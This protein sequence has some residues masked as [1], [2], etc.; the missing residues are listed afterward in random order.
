MRKI[1]W[2]VLCFALTLG[3][4]WV[5]AVGAQQP[6][7]K[8]PASRLMDPEFWRRQALRDLIPYWAEHAPD[9]ENGGFFMNLSRDWK[10]LP[11]WDKVPALI[12][13]H[14]FGFSAAYLLSG[15]PKY[16]DIARRGAEYLIGHAWDPEYGGWFDKLTPDGKPFVETKSIPLELYTNVGLTLYYIASGEEM[17]LELVQ[18]SVDIQRTH[19]LDTKT[20][21]YVQ[22]LNR[23]LSVADYGKNKH[24]HYG[25]IG[26]LLLNLY[27]GTRDSHVLA[28]EKELAD[29][30]LAKMVDRYSWIHGFRSRFDRDWERTPALVDGREFVSVGAELTAALAFL[31]LYH[32][33][34]DPKYLAAGRRL[35]DQVTRF[36]FDRERGCWYD[37]IETVPPHRPVARPVVW[38]WVQIYGAFLQ[39]QLYRVTGDP[40]YLETFRESEEF[41]IKYMR[42]REQGGVFGSV[43][44]EGSLIGEGHKASDSEWHTSYHEM[45]HA[46]LNCLYLNLYVNRT[47]AV[48][49]YRLDGSK[50]GPRTHFVSLVDD[51]GVRIKAVTMDGQPWT[52]FDAV[53]RSVNVPAGAGHAVRVTF[54]AN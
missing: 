51:P 19:G 53:M 35:G 49:H 24:A 16:L 29:I 50:D 2:P 52:E 30:S 39:L 22:A 34:G 1:R 38:W 37:L 33:S 45:E 36:G 7:E 12:S 25:Y 18:R 15:D 8:Q 44:P 47:P 31:R 43:T 20:G 28:W 21:G 41:F 27:L 23:D 42:D 17:A 26:S 54:A 48:L 40:A 14:V 5:S 9:P 13:R 10:P 4:Q 11:P 3:F 46:L 6:R 32:Q